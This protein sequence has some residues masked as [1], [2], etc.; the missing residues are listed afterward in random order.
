LLDQ[1]AERLDPG[2]RLDTVEQVG[3]VDVP[4]GE[5]GERAVAAVLELD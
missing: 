3:V 1:P 2:L 4:G 5:V